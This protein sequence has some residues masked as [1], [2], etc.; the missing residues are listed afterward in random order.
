MA[1][2][3]RD[4]PALPPDDERPPLMEFPSSEKAPAGRSWS[5]CTSSR[6][7]SS[8]LLALSS[9]ALGATVMMSL[10]AK[11]V[12]PT[13][14]LSCNNRYGHN[15]SSPIRFYS[16]RASEALGELSQAEV[17]AV[18][19][20]FM[21]KTGAAGSRSDP[22]I[23]QWLA[24]PSAVELLRPK[25]KEALA[26]LDGQGPKPARFARVTLATKSTVVE[27][28][29]GPLGPEGPLPNATMEVLVPAGSIPYSKRPGFEETNLLTGIY[30]KT[31]EEVG[32]LLIEAFGKIWPQLE[33]GW[34]PGNGVAAYLPR[35]D[36]LA[37]AGTRRVRIKSSMEPPSP[38]R[39]DSQWLYPVPFDFEV[40]MTAWD[41]AEWKVHHITFC[42]QGPFNSTAELKA[43]H[44]KGELKVC[45]PK[46]AVGDWDTPQQE[47][48]K[49][50]T[51]RTESQE[52]GVAWGPWSFSVT[53]RPSTGMA[54]TDIKF[55]GE[56]VAYELAL[57]DSQAIYGGSARDQFMYSDSAYTMSQWSTSLE[58]GVDCPEDATFLSAVNWMG[59]S[60]YKNPDPSKADTF[61][62]ICVFHWDEDHEIWRHMDG[63]MTRGYVRKTVLVRSIAT[64]GNYDYILDVKFR[65]D[66]EINVETRFAG[67]PET[68][69]TGIGERRFSTI[70]RPDV[71]GIVH[72]HSVAWKVD[73]EIAGSKNALHVTEVREHESDG[74]GVNWMA[75]PKEKVFPTK[76]LEQRFVE[77]EGAGLSTFVADPRV[78]KAWAIVNRNTS[79]SASG[80]ALNPRGYRI[81]L[82]SF[83]TGQVHSATHP[84]VESMPW[85][86]YHLAVT[87]YKDHEYRPSSAYVNF[88]GQRPWKDEYA[89]DLDVFLGN[90]ESLMD[91]DL[92]AWI[93][94][95]KEHIVRQEDIPLVSNF[96]VAFSLQPWN[97]FELNTASNPPHSA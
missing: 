21:N 11:A 17:K 34:V 68:R 18:S 84:F 74:L 32:S 92:V 58:P 8:A 38:S 16:S 26:Y 39:P 82:L 96:G 85:T 33:G 75:D 70:V 3:A 14:L 13:T 66:G 27:Y 1:K 64:V 44:A 5:D 43:A 20:W 24:G 2:Q 55:R 52:S 71:A 88:D 36:A 61:W 25:K 37:P 76:I 67:Y 23:E 31:V 22:S 72:T 63:G 78:P 28:K 51:P 57:M 46:L 86:K 15:Q 81:E 56:R 77:K 53:Q 94:L 19:S 87:Q 93:G 4:M 62:P 41:V 90:N 40:N 97:F 80:S 6:F 7:W 9:A 10:N 47:S 50:S 42:G 59:P 54:I 73:L 65:E 95:N 49:S 91:E 29:V 83:S 69:Y 48:P 30:N 79:S 60:M 45:K 12:Q 35:N 89:Q